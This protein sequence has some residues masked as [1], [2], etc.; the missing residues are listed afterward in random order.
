MSKART[1]YSCQECGTNS[2][3]WLGRCPGC[4]NWNTLVEEVVGGRE[5][6]VPS[7]KGGAPKWVELEATDSGEETPQHLKRL[8]TGIG[9]LDRVLGGG[10]VPDSFVLLGGDPGIGKS[11]LL[12]QMAQGLRARQPDAR[13][14]YVTGEESVDQIRGR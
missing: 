10:L 2:P 5:A 11:T 8:S 4:G 14:L 3:K 7:R 12:L 1:Q 6:A 9:E 13:I